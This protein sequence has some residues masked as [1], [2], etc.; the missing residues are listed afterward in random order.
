MA[1]LVEEHELRPGDP[2]RGTSE[3][4]HSG[5]CVPLI[6]RGV[7]FGVLTVHASSGRRYSDYDVQAAS[8]FAEQASGAIANARLY[9]SE[10]MRGD[11]AELAEEFR[12]LHELE[13]VPS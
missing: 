5:V 2:E 13:T 7:L 12:S 10:R 1:V 11:R 4:F 8:L 6:G 9:E 3:G